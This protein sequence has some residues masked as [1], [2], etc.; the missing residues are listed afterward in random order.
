MGG[1]VPGYGPGLTDGTWLNGLAGGQNQKYRYGVNA[2]G[3]SQAGATQLSSGFALIEID[4]ASDGQGVAL[5]SAYAGRVLFIYNNTDVAVTVYPSY[6][7]NRLTFEQDTINGGA[8][9]SLGSQGAAF[10]ACPRNGNWATQGTAGAG[11]SIVVKD[12][13]APDDFTPGTTQS[14]TLPISPSAS[15]NLQVFFDG[16]NQNAD[17][18]GLADDVVTFE[19]VIP[20]GTQVIEVRIW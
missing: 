14:L 13:V 9:V 18:W 3:A 5:P 4:Q 17:T 8:S 7:N 2:A 1:Q 10:F 16:L 6:A 19:V 15:S 20:I 11:S 12:Y